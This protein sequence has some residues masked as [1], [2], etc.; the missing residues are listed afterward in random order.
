V[1]PTKPTVPGTS[2]RYVPGT[3]VSTGR[4]ALMLM[5]SSSSLIHSFE[6]YISRTI[7]CS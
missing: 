7:S 6:R 1:I 5:T 2:T 3:G 4:A